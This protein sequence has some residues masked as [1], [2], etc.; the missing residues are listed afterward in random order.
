MIYNIK[1]FGAIGDGKTMNT[2]S[3]QK[4]IDTCFENGGGRVRK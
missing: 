3:I 4:A 1:D 2:A